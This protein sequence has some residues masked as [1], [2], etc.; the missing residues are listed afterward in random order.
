[1]PDIPYQAHRRILDNLENARRA[2]QESRNAT[3][4]PSDYEN[5][6]TAILVLA[7]C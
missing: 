1:M 7:S 4:I 2:A 5:L 3:K 6:D